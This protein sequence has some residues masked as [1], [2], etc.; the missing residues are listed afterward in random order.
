MITNVHGVLVQAVHVDETGGG[1]AAFGRE[2]PLACFASLLIGALPRYG[3]R[4]ENI[5]KATGRH[6]FALL[7]SAD[8]FPCHF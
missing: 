3:A 2:K 7:R 4:F 5:Q 1:L 6:P 8:L